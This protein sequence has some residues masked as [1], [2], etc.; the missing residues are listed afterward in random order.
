[1]KRTFWL[2]TAAV[3][4]LSLAACSGTTTSYETKLTQLDPAWVVT[5]DEGYE[6]ALV[7]DASIPTLTGSPGWLSFLTFLEEKLVEYGVVDVTKNRWPFERYETSDDPTGW[8]LVSDGEP[9]NVAFYGA[10]SGSTGPD[11]ITAPL[12]YYDHD[13]PPASIEGKI[14]VIP[15]RPHP[16]PPFDDA[17]LRGDT[18]NDYEY[19]ADDDTYPPIFEFVDPAVTFT[20]DIYYQMRQRLHQIAVDGKAAGLVVVYD[21]SFDRT[22]GMY[23]FGVPA[24][25][26]CPTLTLDRV[27][28]AE[29]IADAKAGKKATL[30][31]EATLE[32]S[33]AY[34]LIAYLPG[35]DYGTE[36]DEQILLRTHTDGPSI[37]QD[38]GALGLL[39]IVKYFSHIP[40]E[41]RPRTLTVFLDCRH[42]M[43][44][45]ERA[46]SAQSWEEKHPEFREPIVA[47]VA[48]E[49]LGEM[50]YAERG[51]EV[52]ATGLAEQSQL[53]TRNNQRLIDEAIKAVKQHGWPRVQVQVPERPGVHGRGQAYWW[54]MGSMAQGDR[55]RGR[56]GWDIPA[57][58]MG[59]YLGFY[60]STRTRIDK[61]D[62][63]VYHAQAVTM[64]QL[65][66]VLMA[67]DLE[68]I[69][70]Q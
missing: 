64:T 6:W 7:K 23:S 65:T 13:D 55:G 61:W 63:D 38:N 29:V 46:F 39:A 41:S 10:Y 2:S 57:Y 66:G 59:G 43:P 58:G 53:W 12:V 45:A 36:H 8:S 54:G 47:L 33:E 31:L 44:G 9:V 19:R 24:L 5:P 37:T 32:P 68:E 69:R 21:M 62:K 50:E 20:F 11:G 35:K 67:A 52:V 27:A 60:W 42:Y 28:G 70:P 1:M 4:S 25:Y 40:P 48:T 26:D 51:E 3:L 34:Q 18:F 17:Y 56:R 16:E 49:H 22:A 15:T 30:R 14:V